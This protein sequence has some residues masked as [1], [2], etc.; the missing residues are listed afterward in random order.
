[1]PISGVISTTFRLG[2]LKSRS[3]AVIVISSYAQLER[4]LETAEYGYPSA[5]IPVAYHGQSSGNT[6]RRFD[7]PESLYH[8]NL[9]KL[10]IVGHEALET[11][12]D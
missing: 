7:I 9:E 8:Q 10:Q 1:M 2:M 6:S 5:G 11:L 3:H 12:R 4:S